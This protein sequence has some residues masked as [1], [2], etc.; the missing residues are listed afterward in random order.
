MIMGCNKMKQPV[1]LQGE[2]KSSPI[3]IT[4]R[5]VTVTLFYEPF[6]V[7]LTGIQ[8]LYKPNKCLL[9]LG[10]CIKKTKTYITN[11]QVESL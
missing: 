4:Y 9:K 11:I 5:C 6:T 3:S 1:Q 7:I 10:F 8:G 2:P